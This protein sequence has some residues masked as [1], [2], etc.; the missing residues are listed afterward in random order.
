MEGMKTSHH[1][2]MA[3]LGGEGGGHRRAG[4]KGRQEEGA[5]FAEHWEFAESARIHQNLPK[6]ACMASQKDV[7]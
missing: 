6:N 3:G 4:I 5:F 7:Y 1:F 2:L